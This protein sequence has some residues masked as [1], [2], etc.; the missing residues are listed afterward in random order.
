[1]QVKVKVKVKVTVKVNEPWWQGELMK[2]IARLILVR[3]VYASA[4]QTSNDGGVVARRY[5][6]TSLFQYFAHYRYCC[7]WCCCCCSQ[8]KSHD[9]ADGFEV[10]AHEHEHEHE[11]GAMR[12]DRGCVNVNIHVNDD[13]RDRDRDMVMMLTCV[14]G[15]GD[16]DGAMGGVNGDDELNVNGWNDV[17][18]FD[19]GC[20]RVQACCHNHADRVS[21][22]VHVV[23]TG[24]VKSNQRHLDELPEWCE[25]DCLHDVVGGAVPL[26]GVNSHTQLD[27]SPSH[28]VTWQWIGSVFEWS[29]PAWRLARVTRTSHCCHQWSPSLCLQMSSSLLTPIASS[30]AVPS[31]APASISQWSPSI[32][33]AHPHPAVLLPRHDSAHWSDSRWSM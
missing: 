30:F 16:D 1:M 14:S 27:I 24:D 32:F 33:H 29:L 20:V 17:S 26:L 15:E 11:S 2:T 3:P 5:C 21:V 6:H 10:H 8:W 31:L 23:M 18:C 19:R 13:D 7:Y 9:C 4:H 12:H 25:F 22:E 28:L